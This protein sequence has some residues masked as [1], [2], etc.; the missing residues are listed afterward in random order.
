MVREVLQVDT[1]LILDTGSPALHKVSSRPILF[2]Q[3][4]QPSSLILSALPSLIPPHIQKISGGILI[5]IINAGYCDNCKNLSGLTQ[6]RLI[7][8]S[9]HSP[10]WIIWL[11]GTTILQALGPRCFHLAADNL[12]FVISKATKEKQEKTSG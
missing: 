4:H 5:R 1:R 8:H 7:S 3:A 12:A 10:K 6:S 9:H 11:S 2:F